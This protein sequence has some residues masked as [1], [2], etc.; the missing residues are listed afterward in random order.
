VGSTLGVGPLHRY[1]AALYAHAPAG[2]YVEVR[3]RTALGMEQMFHDAHQLDG[4]AD[5]IRRNTPHT[6]VYVGVLPR[7]RCGGRRDDVV[8]AGGVLWADCDTPDAVAALAAFEP[9]PAMTVASSVDNR[10]AYWLLDDPVP[11]DVIEA[12]NRRLATWLAA[13]EA[14]ADAA[15]ILRP[16]SLNHKHNP[17]QPVRLLTSDAS[18]RHRLVDVVPAWEVA[19]SDRSRSR[20]RVHDD[21]LL[22]LDPAEYVEAL[23][24]VSVPRQ[25]KV[26]CPFHDDHRPSLHVYADPAQGWF[27]FGCR[28]GG[29][30]YEFAA[31]LSGRTTRGSDFVELRRELRIALGVRAPAS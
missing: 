18:R 12:S 5:S 1:L 6:D 22:L 9:Q 11:L 14:C 15:R 4:I 29:S 24:G 17:P 2:S 28:Q 19:V 20:T 26:R 23:T 30:I 10:H 21:E 16:P 7:H 25:R 13:D 27:C 31:L 8:R 3:C